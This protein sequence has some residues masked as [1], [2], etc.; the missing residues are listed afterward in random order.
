MTNANNLADQFAA[1]WGKVAAYFKNERNII[2]LEILNEPFGISSHDHF[3]DW[4]WPGLQNKKYLLPFY[5]KV[6]EQIRK[7]NDEILVFYEPALFDI[8]GGGFPENVGGKS[9]QD[10]EVFSIHVYCGVQNPL[11]EPKFKPLCTFVD[12]LTFSTKSRNAKSLKIGAF[13]TEYGA[14]G[15]TKKAINEAFYV[16]NKADEHFYSWTYWQFKQYQDITT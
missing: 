13:L 2:G 8:L 12:N 16:G 10:R 3:F 6:N 4:M 9:Y 11:G 15:N 14:C 1:F 7:V 5:R